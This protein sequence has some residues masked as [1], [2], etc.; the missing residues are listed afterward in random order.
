MTEYV[1]GGER[2]IGFILWGLKPC[3]L[4]ISLDSDY[5]DNEVRI[6]SCPVCDAEI[7]LDEEDKPGDLIYC[8]YCKC[9]LKLVITRIG[10]KEKITAEY[11]E[12]Y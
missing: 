1:K 12:E 3:G 11:E 2:H 6:I 10:D 7:P 8:D 4:T 9:E 5:D